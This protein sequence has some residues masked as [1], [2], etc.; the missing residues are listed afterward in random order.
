MS[1]DFVMMKPR[2]EIRSAQDL[3]EH[4]LLRQEPAAVV[5]ALSPMF[6]GLA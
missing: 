5:N 2:V 1:Y 4:S 3:G 6:P